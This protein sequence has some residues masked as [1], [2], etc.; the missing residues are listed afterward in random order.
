LLLTVAAVGLCMIAFNP[1][2]T[3]GVFCTI[4]VFEELPADPAAA[5]RTDLWASSSD[6][7]LKAVVAS[8]LMLAADVSSGS[9]FKLAETV[10]AF[11]AKFVVACWTA[12]IDGSL[13]EE[14]NEDPEDN[15]AVVDWPVEALAVIDLELFGVASVLISH[16]SV[17]FD[18][19]V[20][21]SLKFTDPVVT[22][23]NSR[24][25]T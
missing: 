20:E 18:G 8:D 5:A 17:V 10:L 14:L 1:F 19:G 22:T 3:V 4:L 16:R 11:L 23:P 25:C 2:N 9:W 12:A 15:F 6:S 21:A 13:E 24:D 7:A